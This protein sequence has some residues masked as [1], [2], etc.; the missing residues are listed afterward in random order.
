MSTW[1]GAMTALI[2]PFKH[3]KVDEKSL[4]A[5]VRR[6][7]EAGITA[8]VPV[9][10]T[11][12]SPTLSHQEA[13]RVIQVTI[14]E[15]KGRVRVIAGT[16]N[17]STANTVARTKWARKAGADA[18]LVVCPYYSKPTQ[19]G[20]YLH[21]KAAAEDG[22]LPVVIYTIPGR[23]VINI[24]PDTVARLAQVKNIAAVKEASGNL[25]QMAE[26]I[27]TCGD[28]LAVLSGD[29]AFTL[30]LMAL[31]G[32]GVISVAANLVPEAMVGLVRDAQRGDFDSARQ[33][34]Y[35][36]LPLFKAL[37][38]ETNP[39]GIKAALA[40]KKR[41]SAEIR[42]PMTPAEPGTLVALKKAMA[43]LGI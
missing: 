16:G 18:A 6:Q 32:Q 19:K 7:I 3:G 10:T 39:I 4:R 17:Y 34:H 15:A 20:V 27:A 42:L 31:G 1:S 13:D 21:F 12:E 25:G 33:R 8:L 29:D 43:A 26:I 5:L 38:A 24:T 11:G 2:T 41:C 35:Q 23:S 14:A 37:F 36:L 30:P 22:G 28:R 9:G 40:L